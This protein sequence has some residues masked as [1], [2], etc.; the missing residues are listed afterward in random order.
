MECYE[1]Y[2]LGP[3]PGADAATLAA[4]GGKDA[5]AAGS[6]A[7]TASSAAKT[8]E[9]ET[10]QGVVNRCGDYLTLLTADGE[11]VVFDFGEGV[12]SSVLE[13]G[14]NVTVTYTGYLNSQDET[15][16]AIAIQK[17]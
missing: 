16:V 11:Y 13:E 3:V 17:T 15:P 5:P 9:G 6:P 4:C 1:T 7:P 14:D 8:P 12:D 10:I 2:D